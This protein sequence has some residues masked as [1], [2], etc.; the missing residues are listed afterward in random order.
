MYIYKNIEYTGGSDI[1]DKKSYMKNNEELLEY[2]PFKKF[3]TLDEYLN[4]LEKRNKLIKQFKQPD[5]ILPNSQFLS[6][7]FKNGKLHGKTWEECMKGLYTS[8]CPP[9]IPIVYNPKT[10]KYEFAAG[11]DL[12]FKNNHFPSGKG[13]AVEGEKG[14]DLAAILGQE[15]LDDIDNLDSNTSLLFNQLKNKK[16]KETE[17]KSKKSSKSTSKKKSKQKNSKKKNKDVDH[18]HSKS[19]KGSSNKYNLS[20]KDNK[21]GRNGSGNYGSGN[22]GLGDNGLGSNKFGN[23]KSGNNKSGTKENERGKYNSFKL[24][25]FGSSEQSNLR[26]NFGFDSIFDG[27]LDDDEIADSIFNDLLDGDEND[28]AEKIANLDID[29]DKKKAILEKCSEKILENALLNKSHNVNEYEY[30]PLEDALQKMSALNGVTLTDELLKENK[31]KI[32]DYLANG[33][34]LKVLKMDKNGEIFQYELNDIL[35]QQL[36]KRDDMNNLY[37]KR[38]SLNPNNLE[39]LKDISKSKRRSSDVAWNLVRQWKTDKKIDFKVKIY[40][41]IYIIFI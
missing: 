10:K 3:K 34:D 24:K 35:Q 31:K 2:I 18:V 19:R 16:K 32:A 6:E 27:D 25:S 30:D 33:G 37:K 11:I 20:L 23:N 39:V 21:S 1:S 5:L 40:I 28:L 41:Y 9:P 12:K 4:E 29:E 36:Q 15:E 7:L 17:K 26:R 38:L 14:V 13:G 8:C 22:N